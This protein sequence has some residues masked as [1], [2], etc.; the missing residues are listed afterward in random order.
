MLI[1]I[2]LILRLKKYLQ[3]CDLTPSKYFSDD[4]IPPKIYD[5]SLDFDYLR[6]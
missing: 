4:N 6:P 1:L 5:F 2:V 3:I